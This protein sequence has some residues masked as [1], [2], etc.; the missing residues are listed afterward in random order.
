MK[1]TASDKV[2]EAVTELKELETD[3]KECERRIRF[4][5][6]FD[7]IMD[8]F[9]SMGAL[10]R[11]EAELRDALIMDLALVE[12][13]MKDV[14]APHTLTDV[15]SIAHTQTDVLTRTPTHTFTY[16]PLSRSLSRLRLV[17]TLLC[18]IAHHV[19]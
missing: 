11:R 3:V 4:G 5:R 6:D 1:V 9:A 8:Y 12:K 18:D 14:R 15:V 7:S 2:A 13:G 19:T 17:S 10:R 16:F